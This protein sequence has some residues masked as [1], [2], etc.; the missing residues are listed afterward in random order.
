MRF[1][2]SALGVLAALVLLV[3]S[4]SMNFLFM[5][6]LG[7]NEVEGL[8]L[9]GASAAADVL[10][11]LLP[12]WIAWAWQ[13][14][15]MLFVAIG[16]VVFL[17]FTAFSLLSALGFAADNRGHV[18]GTREGLN[19]TYETVLRDL[20]SAEAKRVALPKH[21]PAPVI[22]E[23]LNAIKQDKRWSSS[24][25]CEDATA[26]ASRAFCEGYFSTRAE[27]AASIED[28]R[29]EQ[30]I[31][32]LKAEG[33]KLKGQGAGQD[34][35]P[36]VS[37]VSR[38]FKLDENFVRNA[39]VIFAALLV[40]V[41]SGLGLF[42]ATGHSEVFRSRRAPASP[43]PAT[44]PT[45]PAN[46]SPAREP[47]AKKSRLGAGITPAIDGGRGVAALTDQRPV[48]ARPVGDVED[49]CLERL[50]PASSSVLT[51]P[52]LF[53]DYESWCDAR[54]YAIARQGEFASDFE[55]IAEAVG[56]RKEGARYVGVKLGALH[57]AAAG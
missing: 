19:A 8:V 30:Q 10:K 20:E 57:L 14:R 38:L 6:S 55:R 16:S 54:G 47:R 41:G 46:V 5:K 40:E 42:L 3:V 37:I 49:Y 25:N 31:T 35:D 50:Q 51:L 18:A 48:E 52:D 17:F 32:A 1:L 39:L 34:R 29:L 53:S 24:K 13:A 12:F 33:E 7:K 28:Q 27:L 2:L 36:Q 23:A 11:A 22:E 9:G 26:Q 45:V 43:A 15:R 21:R 4:G 56:I 44:E